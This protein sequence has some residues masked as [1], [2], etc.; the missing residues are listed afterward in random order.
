MKRI[1][2]LLAIILSFA[3][4]ILAQSQ[5]TTGNIEGH[6]SDQNGAV[7]PN[8]SVSATNQDTRFNKTVMTDN[9]GNYIFVLLPPGKYKVEAKAALGFQPPTF[10]N[11]PVTVGGKTSLEV[12]LKVGT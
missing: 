4:G 10:E 8:V 12:I 9:G 7:V 1:I 5:A 11:V 6:V 2:P 3:I